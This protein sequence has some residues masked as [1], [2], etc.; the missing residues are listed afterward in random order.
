M[1]LTGVVV[2]IDGGG[3]KTDAVAATP[4]GEIV[5]RRRIGTTS[6]HLIGVDASAKLVVDLVTEV[7]GEAPP[8]AVAVYLSGL[9][10]PSEVSTYRAALQRFGWPGLLLVDNDVFALLRAGTQQPDAVAVVCGTGINAVGRR[11]DGA[12]VRFPALGSISGDCGGGHGLGQEALWYAARAE[13]GR[14]EPTALVAAVCA[15]FG[16]ASIVEL[17]EQLH[18]GRRDH[19]ELSLLAPAVFVAAAAGDPVATTLVDRLAAEI[20]TMAGTCLRRLDLL[21]REV[22]VVLGGGILQ[23]EP[24]LLMAR[25]YEGLRSVAPRAQ[26]VPLTAPP[27]LGAVQLALE[28]VEAT[29]EA[30]TRFEAAFA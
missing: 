10:L 14:G 26:V 25:V 1:G 13:D 20:V 30:L 9:D 16:V 5:A 29:P 7:C 6:P 22:P 11:A 23:A 4:A 8:L 18:V 28:A 15:E 27:I 12:T 24:P 19:G 21:E 17:T 3:S 2:G